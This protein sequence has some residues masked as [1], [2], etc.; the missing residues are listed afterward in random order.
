MFHWFVHVLVYL[1]SILMVYNI[2]GFICFIH[3]IREMKIGGRNSLLLYFPVVLLSF[4]LLG[5]LLVGFFGEPDLLV[6]GILFGGSIFVFV[7]YRL[8]T[9]IIKRVVTGEHLKTEL[10]AA[11]KA[12]QEKSS[13]LSSISHEMR[14]PINVIL[15]MDELCLR[16]Q[17]LPDQTREML[18]KIGYSAR[19]LSGLIDDILDMQRIEKGE[20]TITAKPF[21]LKELLEQ[22]SSRA[23]EACR[24]KGLEYRSDF[25]D[26]VEGSFVGDAIHLRQALLCLLD[27]AEKFTDAPGSVEF[28]VKCVKR[29]DQ[30][31]G[32][33]S[34][35]MQFI[36]SDTGIGIDEAFLPRILEPFTQE[37][38]S[39][40][41]RFSGSGIGLSL[42]NSIV[43]EMGG[44]IEVRSRK[45][46]GS[47]FLVLLPL[48]TPVFRR[49]EGVE[50]R[51]GE[52]DGEAFG[53]DGRRVLIVEDMK[54]N[55]EILLD[56]LELEGVESD[57]A[58]NGLSAVDRINASEEGYY[59]AVLMDL[60][61]PVM[62]GWEAARKI[63]ELERE[64]VRTIPILA[65]SANG[66]ES[67]I[68]NSLESGMNEHLFKPVDAE[69]LYA[70]LRFWIH[71]REGRA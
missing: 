19:H 35:L 32:E 62:D 24:N 25:D 4:F 49:L 61:M 63:R 43:T 1:G 51:A 67:D 56:L 68:R 2:Y 16:N 47:T 53:L 31:S 27:N 6:A 20:L 3:Y 17:E 69:K 50:L 66:S 23:A 9:L 40:S 54:E 29:T 55:A 58:E 46:E 48:P 65:V 5:Y 28:A 21:S 15:G 10:L 71:K 30:A 8:L 64:D 41:S 12:N 7:I 45:G 36:V 33:C 38:A 26:C 18:E 39:Y 57:W 59:D 70:S 22:I 52:L 13:F 34:T 11:E 42:A 44:R 37:D 14:T 60:R